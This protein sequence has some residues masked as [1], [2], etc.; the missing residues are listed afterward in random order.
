MA[1]RCNR[2]G[3]IDHGYTYRFEMCEDLFS[4]L[5]GCSAEPGQN[6][7]KVF[8]RSTVI[9]NPV[10]CA[11]DM[12]IETEGVQDFWGVPCLYCG[13]AEPPCRVVLGSARKNSDFQFLKDLPLRDSVA[14]PPRII[15]SFVS[16]LYVLCRKSDS[17]S[18]V[19]KI[20]SHKFSKK[21][22]R[23]PE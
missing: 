20:R 10:M 9:C 5:C 7:V 19:S 13:F 21:I 11:T 2:S 12:E 17:S 22:L 3:A 6:H 18:K 4:V 14:E 16:T 8:C 23:V 1:S 15:Y